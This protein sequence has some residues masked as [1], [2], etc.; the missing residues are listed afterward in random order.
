MRAHE[1]IPQLV[2]RSGATKVF[3]MLGGT[4]VAWLAYGVEHG[5]FD[6]V[7]TRHEESS[8][9]A[10]Y[11]YSRSTGRLGVFTVTQGPGFANSIN[12]LTVAQKSHVPVLLI[13]GESPATGSHFTEQNIDQRAHTEAIGAGFHH[14]LAADELERRF[15]EAVRAAFWNGCP[16]VL[17][18]ADSVVDAEGIQLSDDPI[19]GV[20][21]TNQPDFDAVAVAVDAL[22]NAKR[23]LILAGQGAVLADSRAELVELADLVGA[24]VANTLGANCF[25]AGHP[26]DLGLC[27]TWSPEPARECLAMSD[28]V[29]AFG[30]SLN[31]KT[32]G[33][34]YLFGNAKIFQCEIDTSRPFK[35]SQ[36]EY[37]LVGDA[38]QAALAII[39]EWKRRGLEARP[40]QGETP[41][42]EEIRDALMKVDMKPSVNQLLDLRRIYSLMDRK[43]PRSRIVI[44]DSGSS[45]GTLPNLI[46]APDAKHWLVGRSYGS[47]GL[48]LGIAIGAAAAHPEAKVAAFIGDGGF[49]MALSA[50]DS[51]RLY[52]MNNVFIGIMN[53][54]AYGSEI[55]CLDAAGMPRDIVFQDLPDIPTLA[56]AYGAVGSVVRTYDELTALEICTDRI[57]IVDFRTDPDILGRTVFS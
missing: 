54:E 51:F 35:A 10:A 1:A 56:A 11:G 4:N 29:I 14:V 48:G 16:Q 19:E 25:F 17:S 53:N 18:I 40:V 39:T 13:V 31:E 43:L 36:P 3:S 6:L 46:G 57:Q 55:K 22:E 24:R 15:R 30:A 42:M 32:L 50:L 27:G 26:H 45:L 33:E 9:H 28:A 37:G 21:P 7:K 34:G 47:V 41:S 49:M 8:G 52:G 38:R 23:P 2:G 44:T 12:A 5:Y 20:R